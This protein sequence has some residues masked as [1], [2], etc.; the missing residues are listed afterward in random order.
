MTGMILV[1]GGTGF[2]GGAIVR[3]LVRRGQPV[4]VLSHRPEQARRRFPGLDVEV[5][6]GDARTA[7]SLEQ[8]VQ[9][10]ETVISCM[11]FP[12]FP[13]EDPRKGHT[14]HEVDA[15]GN[16]RLVAAATRAG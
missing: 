15:R 13:V 4:A 9:G 8:A 1:A 11:Q 5:R 2:V 10:I 7:A 12:N 14:F 3:E 16:E 6:G